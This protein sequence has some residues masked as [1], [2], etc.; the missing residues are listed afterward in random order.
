M[1]N[2]KNI[3]RMGLILSLVFAGGLISYADE[4]YTLKAGV[5][6]VEKVPSSFM[7]TWR[8][9]AKLKNTDSPQNF[10]QTS[11]DIWN[12]SKK[13]SV[14]NLSNPFTGASASIN[15]SYV[16]GSSIKFTKVGNYDNQKLTDTVEIS[17]KGDTFSGIN[18]LTLVTYSD[19][20][21]SVIKTKQAVYQ[22]R[23]EKI[24]GS[25]IVGK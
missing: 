10:K 4:N 9:S 7:G 11:V 21:N 18:T 13:G 24:S 20:D 15:V 2:V 14:I 6:L 19:I 16:D 8:V 3:L 1:L 22:L 5:S 25:S 17:L 23:G 12:L